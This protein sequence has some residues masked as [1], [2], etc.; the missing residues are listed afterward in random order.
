MMFRKIAFAILSI[1]VFSNINGQTFDSAYFAECEQK[2]VLL[3][4]EMI[5]AEEA[6]SSTIK[7]K[8]S[9]EFFKIIN[10]KNSWDYPFDSLQYIGKIRS[11]HMVLYSW[12]LP[13]KFGYNDYFCIVQYIGKKGKTHTTWKLNQLKENIPNPTM[14]HNNKDYWL[15]TLYY[16]IIE[17]KYKG[18]SFF[19][20]LGFDYNNLLSNKKVLDVIYISKEG[21]LQ[22]AKNMFIYEGKVSNRMVFEYAEA[23]RMTLKYHSEKERIVFDHLSPS[24]PTLEEQYQFYGPDSS[25]DAFYFKDG[26]WQGEKNIDIT[27]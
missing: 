14:Y 21:K 17:T 19:T 26:K 2:L 18:T 7:Q 23:A 10:T 1:I 15:G 27:N 5:N 12:N 25:Y 20:L 8:F 24:R 22:F 11:E 6:Q 16:Q 3:Y 9:E 4:N 13:G